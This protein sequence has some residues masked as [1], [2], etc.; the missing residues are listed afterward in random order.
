MLVTSFGIRLCS[1]TSTSKARSVA[2]R[3][4]DTHGIVM[5]FN[6]EH[7]ALRFF[8]CS[9]V[10]AFTEESERLFFG[11]D[12][13]TRVESVMVMDGFKNYRKYFRIFY[14]FDLMLSG[15]FQSGLKKEITSEHVDIMKEFIDKT[16]N[17]VE[18]GDAVHDEYVVDTFNAY[19]GNKREVVINLSLMDQYYQ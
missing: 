4:A 10:S 2:V 17:G 13:R 7:G 14:A 11:G 19:V 12:Y 5:Q 1:P 8:D 9:Y 16:I 6:N 18:S 15:D 3:F